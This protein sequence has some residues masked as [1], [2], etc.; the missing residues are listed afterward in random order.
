MDK[1]TAIMQ[2]WAQARLK[3][4]MSLFCQSVP[5]RGDTLPVLTVADADKLLTDGLAA[6]PTGPIRGYV[7]AFT[8]VELKP[9]GP[10]RRN[11]SHPADVNTAAY[12]RG[13]TSEVASLLPKPY[14][15]VRAVL[16]PC[17]VSFDLALGFYQVPL[18]P[19]AQSYAAFRDASGRTL[20]LT[21]MPMGHC[22]AVDVM[23]LLTMALA[24]CSSVCVPSECC[25]HGDAQVYVDGARLAGSQKTCAAA[26]SWWSARAELFGATFKASPHATRTYDFLGIHFNHSKQ[27]V[28]IAPHTLSKFPPSIPE[29]WSA[30][31]LEAFIGRAC[32]AADVLCIPLAQHHFALKRVRRI[33]NQL[34]RGLIDPDDIQTLSP[35]CRTQL[36]N[37]L[38]QCRA[39][40]RPKPEPSGREVFLYSDA[41]LEGW[42]AVLYETGHP[43]RVAGA[44]WQDHHTHTDIARLELA[45]VRHGVAAFLDVLKPIASVHLVVD[46]TTVLAALQKGRTRADDI[47]QQLAAAVPEFN[48]LSGRCTVQY[49]ASKLNPADIPS[50]CPTARAL[51]VPSTAPTTGLGLTRPLLWHH[52]GG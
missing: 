38:V 45:A 32:W 29:N 27:Q 41:S 47:A 9:D 16:Q 35:A 21:R 1:L 17:G 26:G 48:Q 12:N 39:V 51:D 25:P 6:T 31:H 10:R 18:S 15:T 11:I 46:N 52:T 13:F 8:V 24:G 44:R 4:L 7:R 37:L 49:I 28:S 30:H 22:A 50:R 42:G 36:Q 2:P 23:Q 40:F 34:N 14:D 43:P 3:Y 20:L 33:F 19:E 5:Q